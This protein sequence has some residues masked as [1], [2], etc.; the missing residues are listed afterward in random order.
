MNRNIVKSGLAV[1]IF[2]A[3]ASSAPAFDI[4]FDAWAGNFGFRT[5]RISTDTSY[6]GA[7]YFWGGNIFAMQPITDGIRFEGG[8]FIDPILRN[9][10]YGLLSYTEKS[11][12][13]GV[14][15]FMGVFNNASMPLKSGISILLKIELPGIL[16]ASLKSENTIGGELQQEGDYL[17]ERN[18]ISFGFYVRNAI[19]SLGMNTKKFAQLLES[20]RVVDSLTA[21]SFHTDIFQKNVPYRLGIHL[22]YENLSKSYVAGVTTVSNVLNSF[23]VGLR[24][25]II[26]SDSFLLYANLDSNLYSFGQEQLTGGTTDAFLFRASTGFR[27]HLDSLTGFTKVF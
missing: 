2:C 26:F 7:T 21:Y 3:A 24:L 12:T 25:D 9:V 27:L 10:T 17:L 19:C 13:I 1:V 20:V 4:G 23:I 6:P 15:P 8:F 16:F 11:L 18:D 14:G 5:D 22:S